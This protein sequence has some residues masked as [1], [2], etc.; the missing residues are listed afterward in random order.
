M[1]CACSGEPWAD[2]YDASTVWREGSVKKTRVKQFCSE[3]GDEIPPGSRL[4]YAAGLMDGRW[5]M[6]YRCLCCSALV[7]AISTTKG[8]CVNLWGGLQ[9]ACDDLDIDWSAWREK[10]KP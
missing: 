1:S 7:E 2:D 4:C 9:E 6:F 5:D 10:F 8:V 3:C